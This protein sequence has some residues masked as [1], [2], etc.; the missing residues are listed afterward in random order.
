[1]R[2][3]NGPAEIERTLVFSTNAA[4]YIYAGQLGWLA[5]R[6]ICE[7]LVVSKRNP[8]DQRLA[9]GCAVK[10][11]IWQI[12]TDPCLVPELSPDQS[13]GTAGFVGIYFGL[14]ANADKS[15]NTTFVW[16]GV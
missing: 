1:M 10:F 9:A 3:G 6:F 16:P 5:F 14:R 2:L 4:G 12:H 11:N 7:E 8:F 15:R 13:P